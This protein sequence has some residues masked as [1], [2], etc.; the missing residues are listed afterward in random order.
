MK[1]FNSSHLSSV[2]KI[3]VS[4]FLF[5]LIL[6][7]LGNAAQAE[8]VRSFLC[9]L[10]LDEDG[11]LKVQE[12]IVVDFQ[13]V[14]RHGL[15]RF[16][17]V[18]YN[19]GVGIY[20]LKLKVESVTDT[21][22]IPLNYRVDD[23]GP[24]VSL[25]IGDPAKLISGV[26]SY[27][28]TYRVLKAINFF[29]QGPELYWNV[30][31]TR[32]IFPIDRCVVHFQ[33]PDGVP[34]TRVKVASFQGFKGAKRKAE[35]SYAHNCIIIGANKLAPGEGLTVLFALPEGSVKKPTLVDETV[36]FIEDWFGLVLWPCLTAIALY[37]IWSVYGRDQKKVS[38][39]AV[40]WTPPPDLTPA[41]V[42]TVIDE[43][44]DTPDVLST[45]VD[46]A[47]RGYLKIKV[48]TYDSG[49]LFLSRKN[50]QF[51]KTEPPKD[52]PPLKAHEQIFLDAVFPYGLSVTTLSMLKG[53]FSY[54]LRFIQ[55]AVWDSLLKKRL[56]SRN[57]NADVGTFYFV[58]AIIV[59]SGIAFAILSSN[60]TRATAF[61]IVISG[62]FVLLSARAMPQR[63]ALGSLAL[64]RCRAFQRF[65]QTA[66]KSRIEVLAKDDPTIFGRLLPYAMV[67]GAADKWAAAF[68][69]LLIKPPEWYD[70]SALG[71][72][73]NYFPNLFVSDL[74]DSMH[75]I[76]S[77]L[78]AK[79]V[80]AD[81]F[82]TPGNTPSSWSSDAG[83]GFSG[84]SE[85][86]GSSGGG[87]GGGG[88]STW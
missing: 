13:G 74:G 62:V 44:L 47:S 84:F 67:L 46:L 58:G 42:G 59:F 82:N 78:V 2:S 54:S 75:S 20:T 63:T 71:N 16:I 37:L 50:Y 60:V 9:D 85:G 29:S 86:G 17:P 68:K 26:Q 23:V 87:F 41:E 30:N 24:D 64:A 52:A 79:S 69:D 32:W 10:C 56:F 3:C 34:L 6:V 40:E 15:R 70:N 80:P 14:S 36:I 1:F 38:S 33:P 43:K 88:G 72:N 76:A 5:A 61:G 19:R 51:T 4:R 77:G 48:I 57:P 53:K 55:D 25:K 28:I 49:F 73:S 7:F 65:V 12:D 83:S 27:R 18:T 22:G 21:R 45:L 66:E 81:T 11:S 8:A 31:G 35:I 39:I